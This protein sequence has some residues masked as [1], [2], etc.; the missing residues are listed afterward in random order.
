MKAEISATLRGIL[1]DTRREIAE[2]K[3]RKG[4]ADL[5]HMARDASLNL[6]EHCYGRAYLSRRAVAALKAVMLH[7]GCLH[8]VKV[9][10]GTEAFDGCNAV[11]LM[12]HGKGQA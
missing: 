3:S 7:E 1:A 6:F 2:D 8:W 4:V 5:K 10:S 9:L 11:A 12:H